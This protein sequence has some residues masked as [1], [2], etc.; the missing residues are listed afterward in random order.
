VKG[1]TCGRRSVSLSVSAEFTA[2]LKGCAKENLFKPKRPGARKAEVSTL[3][4][5]ELCVCQTKSISQ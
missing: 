5:A 3:E 2:N 4:P 1:C